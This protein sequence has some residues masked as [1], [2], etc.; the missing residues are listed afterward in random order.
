M[1][2]RE[3][4]YHHFNGISGGSFWTSLKSFVNKVASGVGSVAKIAAP[5]VGAIAPQF[6]APIAGVGGLASAV[7]NATGGRLSGG[8]LAGTRVSRRAMKR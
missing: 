3:V 7:E 8:K 4:D 6:A 5:I 1:S 2:G